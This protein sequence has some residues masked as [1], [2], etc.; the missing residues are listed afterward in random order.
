[1]SSTDQHP[2]E[3]LTADPRVHSLSRHFPTFYFL[4]KCLISFRNGL[5]RRRRVVAST[6]VVAA[7]LLVVLYGCWEY[8]VGPQ[9]D[10]VAAIQ[11]AGGSAFYEWEWTSGR[12]A[13]PGTEPPWPKWLV[14]TLGRDALGNVVAV[15]LIGRDA[16]DAL[17]THIGCLHHLEWLYLSDGIRTGTGFAQLEKLTALEI[18][19][20]PNHRFSDDDLGHLAGMTKLKQIALTGPQITDKGLAH[21]AGMRQMDSLQLIDTKITTLEPIRGLTQLKELMLNGSPIGDEGLSPLEGFTSLQS[22]QLAGTQVTD[23]GITHFS[24]LSNLTTLDLERTRVGDAGVRRLLDLPRIMSLNL[25]D[26]R[27]TDAGLVEL[28]D[29]MSRG[30]LQR[31][32][33]WGARVTADGVDELREKLPQVAVMGPTRRRLRM[34]GARARVAPAASIADEELPR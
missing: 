20:L 5:W 26:T 17:M 3:A 15:N 2:A 24:T 13:P 8:A 31:L 29:R 14:Q 12:P 21:L 16:D 10:A 32:V 6:L 34:P 7:L 1:M 28:A 9:R 33:V 22:L 19:T 11:K 27:V 23:A 25:D 18:L 30:P 4:W